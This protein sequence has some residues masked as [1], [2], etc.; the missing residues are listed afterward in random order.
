MDLAYLRRRLDASRASA[1]QAASEPAR[2][3]HAALASLYA[4][5]IME[6]ETA[7]DPALA[8]PC[9]AGG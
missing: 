7:D 6:A 8:T 3:A 4:R 5:R 9:D 2:R 1:T